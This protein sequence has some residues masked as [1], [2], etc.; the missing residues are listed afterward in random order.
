[1][2]DLDKKSIPDILSKEGDYFLLDEVKTSTMN[3]GLEKE[4]KIG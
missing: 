2:Q 3:W 4:S 1:M